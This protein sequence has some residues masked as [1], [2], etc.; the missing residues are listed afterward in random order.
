[1]TADDAFLFADPSK[2]RGKKGGSHKG[3]TTRSAEPAKP[4]V[5]SSL[6]ALG[7]MS[8]LIPGRHRCS[9]HATRHKLLANCLSCGR[10][11]CEQ[12]GWGECLFC[13]VHLGKMTKHAKETLKESANKAAIHK[14]RLLEFQRTSAKRTAVIDDQCDWFDNADVNVWLNKEEQA[15]A[16]Q[17]VQARTD[18]AE[19]RRRQMRVT[20]DLAGRRVVEAVHSDSDDGAEPEEGPSAAPVSLLNP[21]LRGPPPVFTRAGQ[22]TEPPEPKPRELKSKVQHG[23]FEEIDPEVYMQDDFEEPS[24]VHTPASTGWAAAAAQGNR[25]MWAAQHAALNNSELVAAGASHTSAC[26]SMHQPWA[27]LLVNGIKTVEGRSWP[28]T[29]RGLIWIA[30]TAQ[31][32]EPGAIKALRQQYSHVASKHFPEEYPHGHLL[33][34]VN[35]VDCITQAEYR[36][37]CPDELREE[38]SSEH[39]FVCTDSHR[40]AVPYKVSGSHKIW[41]LPPGLSSRLAGGLLAAAPPSQQQ[42]QPDSGQ[43]QQMAVLD[44]FPSP[45]SPEH[46]SC[47]QQAGSVLAGRHTAA[48]VQLLSNGVVLLKGYLSPEVQCCIVALVQAVSAE[49]EGFSRPKHHS[50]ND[51]HCDMLHMGKKWQSGLGYTSSQVKI[52]PELV[53]LASRAAQEASQLDSRLP[54]AMTPDIALANYYT[55]GGRMGMHQ[56]KDESQ[57]TLD[58]G[59]PVVSFSI[60]DSC[61][62]A[63][64][65]TDSRG[66]SGNEAV[67]RLDSGDVLVFGGPARRMFHG[68]NKVYGSTKPRAISMRPGRLNMTFRQ[69]FL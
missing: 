32:V 35:V 16:R 10:I 29:H 12:E 2:R 49:G 25:S 60:G 34:V 46:Q 17:L 50:G 53:Q 28:T 5:V 8:V 33:G 40:L 64:A 56:D 63:Y 23:A 65:P 21:F 15:K 61:D 59:V 58:A 52:P 7:D 4:A 24:P 41:D 3:A 45:G 57:E 20:L 11:I 36:V 51:M 44:L 13:G 39:L 55:S 19:S 31:P 69:Q 47:L 42:P 9:C 38:N 66:Q 30:S 54:A 48:R 37:Q 67:V 68:V 27:S 43:P 26:L 62:F 22:R 1:M 14:D 18:K 6:A